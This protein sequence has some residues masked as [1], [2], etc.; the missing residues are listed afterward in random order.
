MGRDV[1]REPGAG[2]AHLGCQRFWIGQRAANHDGV[3]VQFA[4]TPAAVYY[5]SPTQIDVQVPNGVS[6]SVPVTLSLDG[7][8]GPTTHA[9]IGQNAPSLFVYYAGAKTYPAATHADGTLIGDPSV[10]GGTTAARPGEPIVLYVNGLASSPAGVLIS[11]P[12]PY[13]APVTVS[14][15][16]AKARISFAGLVALGQ[17]QLNITLPTDLAPGNHVISVAAAGQ[18]SPGTVALPVQ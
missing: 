2:V 7:I 4:Q 13:T 8:P 17:F 14:I 12:V 10:E 15:D 1:W 5:I 18:V 11:T 3:S 16:G 6:G 9:T